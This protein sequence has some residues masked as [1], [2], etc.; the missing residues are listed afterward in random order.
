MVSINLIEID[1]FL[2]WIWIRIPIP[3]LISLTLVPKSES[4]KFFENLYIGF[5]TYKIIKKN[6]RN[7]GAAS[8]YFFM[9]F[10][11]VDGINLLRKIDWCQKSIGFENFLNGSGFFDCHVLKNILKKSKE[12]RFFIVLDNYICFCPPKSYELWAFHFQ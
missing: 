6:F 12:I 4:Y 10:V 1:A 3:I 7:Q 9:M 2:S 5:G 8:K 11:T